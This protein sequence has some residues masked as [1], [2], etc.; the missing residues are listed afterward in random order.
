ME[1]TSGTGDGGKRAA[2]AATLRTTYTKAKVKPTWSGARP[3]E[4]PPWL[5]FSHGLAPPSR[6][7]REAQEPVRTPLPA[8]L[9]EAMP[10]K[11]TRWQRFWPWAWDDGAEDRALPTLLIPDVVL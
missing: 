4:I 2:S 3:V 7:P 8:Y 9:R 1:E 11:K 10:H 6:A 5:W